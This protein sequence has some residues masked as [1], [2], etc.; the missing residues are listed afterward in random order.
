MS[1]PTRKDWILW[2]ALGCALVATYHAEYTLAVAAGFHPWVALAVPG[3]LDLYVIRALQ[4]RRDVLVA[5]L[6]MVA[7][8]VAS[9]LIAKDVLQVGWQVIAAVGAIAPLVLWRVYSLKH[10]RNRQE[11]LHG[12]QAGALEYTGEVSAPGPTPYTYDARTGQPTSWTPAPVTPLTTHAPSCFCEECGQLFGGLARRF[13]PLSDYPPDYP[14]K[15]GCDGTHELSAS[16][17]VCSAHMHRTRP[18]PT[19]PDRI[20]DWMDR[21]YPVSVTHPCALSEPFLREPDVPCGECGHPWGDHPGVQR[22]LAA[23]VQASTPPLPALPPEY[24]PGTAGYPCTCDHPSTTHNEHGCYSLLCPCR[25]RRSTLPSAPVLTEDEWDELT[26]S[27][28]EYLGELNEYIHSADSHTLAGLRA[29]LGIG[30]AR[31]TRLIKHARKE[32]VW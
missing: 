30:Q 21:E 16:P 8:N 6:A 24:A 4:Q 31:A 25:W 11:L 29:A 26:D 17:L 22:K 32:G 10:T 3:A 2:G 9:H 27:D 13:K 5:V 7:A 1:T 12:V 15:D 18:H 19:A 28:R 23:R 20:P 14:H